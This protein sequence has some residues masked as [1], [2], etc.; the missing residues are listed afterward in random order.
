MAYVF[1]SQIK[2]RDYQNQILKFINSDWPAIL[3]NNKTKEDKTRKKRFNE[4]PFAL[5]LEGVILFC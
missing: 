5:V 2:G 1:P 3:P 4:Q